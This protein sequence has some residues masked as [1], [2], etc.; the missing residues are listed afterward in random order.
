MEDSPWKL[1]FALSVVLLGMLA[2]SYPFVEQGTA[3]WVV[4]Q[5]SFAMLVTTLLVSIVL[6]R[7]RWNPFP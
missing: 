5:L 1:P 6:I 3:T 7:I 2:F 4:M